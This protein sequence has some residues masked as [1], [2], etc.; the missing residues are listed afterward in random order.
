MHFVLGII[1]HL[2]GDYGYIN[3]TLYFSREMGRNLQLQEGLSVVY[4]ARKLSEDIPVQIYMIKSVSSENWDFDATVKSVSVDNRSKT[5]LTTHEKWLHGVVVGVERDRFSIKPS[6]T[7]MEVF[8]L[9]LSR[10][11]CTFLPVR[12]I[13]IKREIGNPKSNFLIVLLFSL[14]LS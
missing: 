7:K 14:C 3:D 1:T 12:P 4:I 13:T 9:E 10:I 5:T 6:D 11:D 2:Y 8:A